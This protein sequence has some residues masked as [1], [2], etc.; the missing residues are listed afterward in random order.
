MSNFYDELEFPRRAE[1]L[2]EYNNYKVE[3]THW[4]DLCL[5]LGKQFRTVYQTRSAAVILVHGP[6]GSGKSLFCKRLLEDYNRTSKGNPAKGEAP[7]CKPDLQSNLWHALIA[8]PE[9]SEEQIHEATQKA[10]VSQV[11]GA[12]L[13]MIRETAPDENVRVRV[14]LLD[15]AHKDPMVRPW[16]D[17]D[18]TDFYESRQRG[19]DALIARVAQDIDTACRNNMRRSVIVMFSNDRKWLEDLKGH[20]DRCFGD[21]ATLVDMPVPQ[22]RAVERIVRVNTNRL[23]KVSYWYCV[24]AAKPEKRRDVRQALNDQKKGFT[25]SFNAVS[26]SLAGDGRRRGPP[27]DRNVFTIVTLGAKCAAVQEFLEDR[28][29]EATTLHTDNS[30]HIGAWEAWDAWASKINKKFLRGSRML[31]SEFMFRWV[32]LD[33]VATYALLQ[34]PATND[35]GDRIW[36]L[37]AG[38]PWVGD[39][40]ETTEK[41]RSACNEVNA[42]LDTAPYTPAD[43]QKLADDFHHL[44]QTRS[45]IYEPALKLRAGGEYGR[46]FA[47][48]KS[49]RPDLIVKELIDNVDYGEYKPCELTQAAPKSTSDKDIDK[50]IADA[51]LRTGH[52]IEFTAFLDDKLAKL[53]DYLSEKIVNYAGMLESV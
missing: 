13:K 20:L 17:I 47:V 9:P 29:I 8:A 49:V 48:Y 41:W 5:Q 7:Q 42:A 32:S 45:T 39:G 23:N 34:T 11:S 50:A 22:P 25:N 51:M 6:M 18:V 3:I 33:M 43:V 19:P 38:R 24:D 35:L 52:A 21:L 10:R 1:Y 44:G 14:F 27:R 4:K 37:I 40:D 15:D 53:E 28:E 2:D 46:G 31:E 36:K 26:D 30:H 12:E 16:T